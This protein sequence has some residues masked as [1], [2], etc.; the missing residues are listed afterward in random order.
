MKNTMTAGVMMYSML[1]AKP[2]D[3]SAPGPHRAARERVGAARVRQRRRHL[4]EAEDQAEI[5]DRDDDGGDEQAAPA[6]GA[7]AE[8]PAGEVARDHR[9]D[10][11]RPQR[12]DAR[13][14]LAARASRSSPC[15]RSDRS[16]CRR[17]SCQSCDSPRLLL[18]CANAA[19]TGATIRPSSRAQLRT[20]KCGSQD[21]LP[22]GRQ[23]KRD[24]PCHR[25]RR[26][27]RVRIISEPTESGRDRRRLACTLSARS[28]SLRGRPPHPGR[29]FV[30]G[31]LAGSAMFGP[32][33][34]TTRMRLAMGPKSARK[35]TELFSASTA[36]SRGSAPQVAEHRLIRGL[37]LAARDC[38]V[39]VVDTQQRHRAQVHARAEIEG[40][41]RR[42]AAVAERD[43][44]ESRLDA[45]F[46]PRCARSGAER[47]ID[48]SADA[49]CMRRALRPRIAQDAGEHALRCVARSAP[50]TTTSCWRCRRR[51]D[52]PACR[53]A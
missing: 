24:A 40:T 19:A 38:D 32:G 35:C 15:R 21:G 52:C 17:S 5:H 43:D 50:S 42:E 14:A 27:W 29:N 26:T 4:G 46:R 23:C 30:N 39:D 53:R 36:K 10:A 20:Q 13:V 18:C 49:G 31:S 25:E 2:G 9:A 33:A 12:P 6:A 11:E 22:A 3:E 7:D 37:L 45:A 41:G 44:R 28:A 51:R 8:V 47:E 48:L 34:S 16:R 1:S